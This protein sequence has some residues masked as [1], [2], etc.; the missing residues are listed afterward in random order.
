MIPTPVI[1]TPQALETY[2]FEIETAGPESTAGVLEVI[3]T[4]ATDTTV[5]EKL[6]AAVEAAGGD[7]EI[8][9][10]MPEDGMAPDAE[11]LVPCGVGEYREGTDC[12]ACGGPSFY[13]PFGPEERRDVDVG[14]YCVGG[15]ADGTKC[16]GQQKCAAGHYCEGGVSRPCPAGFIQPKVA[17]PACN[18]CGSVDVICP[19]D[20]NGA[21][22]TVDVT[23]GHCA[24]PVVSPTGEP[25]EFAPAWER[26]TQR[27]EEAACG[28]TV[29]ATGKVKPGDDP[30]P[31]VTMAG[32][33]VSAEE[34]AVFVKCVVPGLAVS[35]LLVRNT[36][37]VAAKVSVGTSS[38]PWLSLSEIDRVGVEVAAGGEYTITTVLNSASYSPGGGPA[39]WQV[40]VAFEGQPTTRQTLVKTTLAPSYPNALVMT[41][42]LM[43]LQL[44]AQYASAGRAP[45]LGFVAYNIFTKLWSFDVTVLRMLCSVL[46]EPERKSTM[47]VW[48]WRESGRV[49]CR[50][51][52]IS[53][54]CSLIFCEAFIWRRTSPM[55]N[56]SSGVSAT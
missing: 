34:I 16:D 8:I 17:Q 55:V 14:H 42:S 40:F 20:P 56:G 39:E 43:Q 31:K 29:E 28:V 22:E 24:L 50:S 48:H 10:T 38:Q 49:S 36:G 52:T 47:A 4:M 3:E 33:E 54:K 2:K 46:S 19:F 44:R 27:S 35:S 26:Q 9:R 18:E 15:P 51:F 23:A 32:S 21:T 5:K 41:P 45:Q 11:K 25:M 7:P 37:A 12:L 6:A 1:P 53:M 30:L 13:C